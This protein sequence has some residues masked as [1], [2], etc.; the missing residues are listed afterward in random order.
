MLVGLVGCARDSHMNPGTERD[1][2]TPAT[3][4]DPLVLCRQALPD[5]DV[6][7]GTW[8]TVGD[9]RTWGYGGPMQ[10][11]PLGNVFPPSAPTEP[12]GWCWTREAIDSYTAWG[13]HAPDAA[14]RAIT[15]IGPTDVIPTGPPVIPALVSHS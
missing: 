11:R 5:R 12:A 4:T 13:V 8:T 15:V 2:S 14:E 1:A 3:M 9:L 10:K 6:V 7:S